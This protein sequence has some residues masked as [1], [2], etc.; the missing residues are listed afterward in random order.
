[1]KW[2]DR[3]LWYDPY[4]MYPPL[5]EPFWN[6]EMPKYDQPVKDL[7]ASEKNTKT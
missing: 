5:H 4:V 6:K 2:E 3:P 7:F 1:M